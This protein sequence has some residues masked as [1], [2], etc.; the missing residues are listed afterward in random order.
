[1]EYRR[2]RVFIDADVLI[3]GAASRT[4]ASHLVLR[5]SELGLVDGLVSSQVVR[6]AQRNLERKLPAALPAFRALVAA[7]CQEVGEPTEAESAALRG[8]AD[9]KD[10]PILAAAVKAGSDWLITFNTKDFRPT[11][12]RLHVGEPGVFVEAL[13]RMLE[14]IAEQ[15]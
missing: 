8:Q 11:S 3:A 1:M 15:R 5:L 13:R 10:I 4:G 7:A 2:P 6:E 9:R 12:G 14:D